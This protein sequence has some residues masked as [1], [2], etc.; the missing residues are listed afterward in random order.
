[1]LLIA[2][3]FCIVG[4]LM[5]PCCCLSAGYVPSYRVALFLWQLFAATEAIDS[6]MDWHVFLVLLLWCLEFFQHNLISNAR[7]RPIN[8]WTIVS[9]AYLLLL[10][11]CLS[12]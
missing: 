10:R 6:S 11:A 8:I 3:V 1:M 7:S 9:A 12:K 4:Q 5:F 2:E